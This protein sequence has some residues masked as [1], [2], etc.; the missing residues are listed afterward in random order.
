MEPIV[1][2]R[3]AE[4][5]DGVS[6]RR[7]DVRGFQ[8]R[9]VPGVVLT[10]ADADGHRPVILLGHG[11][12]GHK[13]EEPL[14]ALAADWARRFDWSAALIDGPIHGD[15]TP[16]E[17]RDLPPGEEWNAA[18][19]R[20][21]AVLHTA[22][23]MAA[24]WSAMIDALA[25]VPGCGNER[26]AYVGFSMGTLLGVPA[27]AGEPRIRCAVFAIGGIR[28]PEGQADGSPTWRGAEALV[29]AAARLGD[30]QVLLLNQ[31]EDEFFSRDDAFRLYDALT[32]P[33]RIMFFPGDHG[34]LPEEAFAY[35]AGFLQRHLAGAE[36]APSLAG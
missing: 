21:M 6:Q 5:G 22:A 15:R 27:V 33:K 13:R 24:D 3:D 20:Q 26:V 14:L 30:R 32:G 1:A 25:D 34:G 17:L 7:L 18:A 8:G 36:I 29:Q 35:A 28:A 2:L 9:R 16:S 19:R 12:G 31:S 23:A 11:M 10:P 4:P